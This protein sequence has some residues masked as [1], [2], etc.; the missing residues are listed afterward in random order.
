MTEQHRA[1]ETAED[2]AAAVP[3]AEPR[4]ES[5]ASPD[6]GRTGADEP[7][8]GEDQVGGE[9]SKD[10]VESVVRAQLSKALGGKRG[11]AEAAVPTVVFT[12]TYLLTTE[13]RL[14]LG[15]GIGAA[16]LLGAVRL[17][18][19]S[20]VQFVVNS[21]L[22]IGVAAVFALRSGQAEDA[23][24]PGII[25]NAGYAAVLI[26]TILIRWP[27]VGLLI[28]AVTGDPTGWRANP[29]ILKLSS[30]LTWLLVLPC[31]VRVVVQ[32]PLWA[33]G[34]VGWLGAAKIL[35]GWPLQVAALAA[36]VWLLARGRTPIET[37]PDPEGERR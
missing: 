14:A 1:V 26:L 29:A 11:M 3:K 30:R 25:Y 10:T 7:A 27:A 33:A 9:I 13:L 21:L 4:S 28:G 2:D 24:L 32:Y 19:R 36:M 17:V 15:L 35:M 6:P 37:D 34:T 16:V 18:Q 22:G 31:V 8:D 20:S 12:V 5:A 23:F